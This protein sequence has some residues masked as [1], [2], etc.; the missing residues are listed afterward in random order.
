MPLSSVDLFLEVGQAYNNAR[1]AGGLLFAHADEAFAD[2]GTVL[3]QLERLGIS[4]ASGRT[5][6]PASAQ[7]FLKEAG[8]EAPAVFVA[9]F[10]RA[11]TNPYYHSVYDGPEKL[12][13]SYQDGEDGEMVRQIAR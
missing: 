9:D 3:G 11:Y 8:R 6:P 12:G 2:R 4:R 10:D 5:L 7:S 1:G 13:Y